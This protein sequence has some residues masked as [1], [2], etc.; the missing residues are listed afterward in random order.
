VDEY[1]KA[2]GTDYQL[3]VSSG[4]GM[5]II[6]TRMSSKDRP[7]L[8]SIDSP[9]DVNQFAKDGL[10]MDLSKVASKDSW[11]KTLF[12][13][14]YSLSQV[15]GKVVTLPYGYEGMVIW[16][17]KDIMKKLGL[18]PAKITDLASYESALKKAADAGYIPIMLGSQNWPWAQEWYLSILYSYTGR[19]L[20]KDTIEGKSGSAWNSAPFR[21]TVG[22]YKSWHDKGY[23]ADKRSYVLTSDDAINAFVNGKALFKLEGTW[24]PYWI[25]PL[26]ASERD[27]IGVMLHPAIGTAEKPHMPLAVGGMWCVSSTSENGDLAGYILTALLRQGIQKDF[28]ANGMDVAPMKIDESTFSGLTPVVADM[29]KLVN[30]ALASG[31]FGYTT[32]AFYPPETRV[33]AYEG[34]VQVLENKLSIEDYLSQMD[35]L[36]KKEL[37]AGFKPVIPAAK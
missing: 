18:D 19:S 8:F 20:V 29:W 15:D 31:R 23:L 6:K 26:E 34:I 22:L 3:K 4:Q 9:A 25:V 21:K 12:G 27:K 5:D 35:K 16:Y 33:Y 24:A 32:W 11:K 28:L 30:G 1:N 14:A 7:D 10:L 36:T 37:A 13:W 2:K 17:N